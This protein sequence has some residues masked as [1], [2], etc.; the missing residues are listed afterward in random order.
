MNGKQA[1]KDW[2]SKEADC[3]IRKASEA[4]FPGLNFGFMGDNSRAGLVHRSIYTEFFFYDRV[5]RLREP[6]TKILNTKMDFSAREYA[7]S[8]SD[9]T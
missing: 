4:Y 1:L 7:L 5:Q 8:K 2:L 6:M 3:S 9:Y